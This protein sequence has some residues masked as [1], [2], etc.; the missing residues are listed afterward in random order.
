MNFPILVVGT[1]VQ[2]LAF[3]CERAPQSGESVVGTFTTAAGGKGFN[4]A[5]A[6]HRAGV[7]TRFIGGVGR[8]GF[9]ENA[10]AFCR[11]IGLR[12]HWIEKPRHATAAAAVVLDRVGQNRIVVALGAGAQLRPRDVDAAAIR[13]ARVVV[14]Q[15]ETDPVV[16]AHVF[17]LARR[18]GVTTLLNPAPMRSGI[19]AAMLADVDVLT[20]NETEFAALVCALV[21][22]RKKFTV[23]RLAGLHSAAL[24]ALCRQLPVPTVI[25]T[26]GARGVLVSQP[27]GHVFLC[28]HKVR[29]VDTTGAGDAFNGGFAAGLVKFNHD[30]VAA[31]RFG[32]T[33]AALSVTRPGA[34]P[35]MPTA[36]E[37]AR[38]TRKQRVKLASASTAFST[39]T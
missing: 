24:H 38:F 15:H 29:V 17:R 13:A 39:Q 9:A 33:V 3:R 21:P 18:A 11:E 4:Q 37:I 22:G 6:A 10:R 28:A 19:S 32:N 34:A 2:D 14:C 5:V 36:R 35:A 16:N 1:Y 23:N 20:P 30:V 7:P 12:A 31:A 8:D 26:L 25:V 27:H